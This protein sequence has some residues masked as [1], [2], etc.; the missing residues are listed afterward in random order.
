MT[1]KA[2]SPTSA[3]KSPTATPHFQWFREDGVLA[4]LPLPGDHMSMVWSAPDALADELVGLSPEALA[5]GQRSRRVP[6]GRPG[7]RHRRRRL[8][9]APDARRNRRQATPGPDRRRRPRHSPPVRPRH[10]PGLPGRP[11]PRR[12]AGSAD[13]WRDPGEL[14]ILRAYARARAEET[15]LLQYTTHGLNRLFKPADPLL[16]GLRNLGLNLTNRL[17]VVR[18][19]LVRYAI[20]GRF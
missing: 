18:N 13:T 19:A 15:A 20:A 12:A 14:S 2:W 5:P 10:Q 16:S 9:A 7:N 17:P 1:K 4:Y 8:P 11:R 6:P 3:A